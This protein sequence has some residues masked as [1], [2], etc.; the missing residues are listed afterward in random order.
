MTGFRDDLNVITVGFIYDPKSGTFTD[1]NPTSFFTIAQGINSKG[2]VVGSSNFFPDDDPCVGSGNPFL[3]YG[4]LRAKNGTV[5]YFSVNGSHTSARGIND[6]G[7]IVGFFRDLDDGGK[8]KGYI[9]E[10]DGSQ[11]QLLTVGPNDILD[12]M[13]SDANFVQGINNKGVISG[14]A[15]IGGSSPG[16]IA[17]PD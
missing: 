1:L 6:K 14:G 2:D 3:R 12:V 8:F 4:W 15:D 11:C 9:A 5:T 13:G 7:S 10:L 16:F 17:R